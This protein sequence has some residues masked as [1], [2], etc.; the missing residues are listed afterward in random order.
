LPRSDHAAW[1]FIAKRKG[2]DMTYKVKYLQFG[3]NLNVPG[4]SPLN[5]TNQPA[6]VYPQLA[7]SGHFWDLIFSYESG[8]FYTA[9]SNVPGIDGATVDAWYQ[10]EGVGDGDHVL[11]FSPFVVHANGSGGF[12]Q[13]THFVDFS[14]ASPNDGYIDTDTLQKASVTATVH[15]S[16]PEYAKTAMSVH[17]T[18]QSIIIT[19]TSTA[20]VF[21]RIFVYAGG[22][23]PV[24]NALT[25][26][27]AHT[28]LALA[29]FNLTT[30]TS[31]HEIGTAQYP[32]IPKT[33]WPQLV[34]EIIRE[35][36][37]NHNGE[38]YGHLNAT[39]VAAMD[40]EGRKVAIATIGKRVEQLDK[41]KSVIAGLGGR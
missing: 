40:A 35:I 30:S 32:K 6:P 38:I 33:E 15:A 17:S 36:A 25:V 2:I 20:A 16:L 19:T 29:V 22:N 31:T 3:T 1:F 13:A 37:A 12:A 14:E 28:C 27:K 10:Q 23:I 21:D 11:A 39:Q 7:S 5:T 26:K 41:I 9:G 34:Y 18:N 24:A 8:A 4:Y